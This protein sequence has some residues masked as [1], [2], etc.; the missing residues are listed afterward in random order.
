MVALLRPQ[1]RTVEPSHHSP[2]FCDF[3]TSPAAQ[4]FARTAEQRP[5][6]VNFPEPI[7]RKAVVA[8]RT[9]AAAHEY[10]RCARSESLLEPP[11]EAD[12]SQRPHRK[13]ESILRRRSQSTFPENLD[14]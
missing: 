4:L 14:R 3:A 9:P 7:P 2:T 10:S 6:V 1:D 8:A 5:S 13:S 11:L 12:I